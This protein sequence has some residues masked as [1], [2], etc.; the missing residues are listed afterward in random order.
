MNRVRSILLAPVTGV[1]VQVAIA[2]SAGDV[3]PQLPPGQSLGIALGI[4]LESLMHEPKK[5]NVTPGGGKVER[6]L[7]ATRRHSVTQL[8][9]R[10]SGSHRPTRP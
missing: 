10:G 7:V 1:G 9:L 6:P 3:L 8:R 2:G 5:A 4:P